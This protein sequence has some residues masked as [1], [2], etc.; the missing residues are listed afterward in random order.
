MT[1]DKEY[2]DLPELTLIVHDVTMLLTKRI[3]GKPKGLNKI[4]LPIN[5]QRYSIVS[6]TSQIILFDC[7]D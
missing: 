6:C 7:H 2:S 3:Y 5:Q 1:I 4:E